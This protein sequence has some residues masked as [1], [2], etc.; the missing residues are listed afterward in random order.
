MCAC[1]TAAVYPAFIYS[2]VYMCTD[3]L[4]LLIFEPRYR[5]M[6]QRIMATNR[7]FAYVSV[8][9][10]SAVLNVFTMSSLVGTAVLI[11]TIV[12][13]QMLTDGSYIIKAKFLYPRYTVMESY[14]EGVY[15]AGVISAICLYMYPCM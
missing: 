15:C 1:V 13:A 7:K 2:T 11:A 3:K 10:T 14:G 8:Q 6:I 9:R 12:E 5:L 4:E